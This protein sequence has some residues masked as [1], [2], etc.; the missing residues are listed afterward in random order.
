LRL[1]IGISSNIGIGSDIGIDI[2]IGIGIGIDDLHL[3]VLA[4]VF[5]REFPP[6]QPL[7][8]LRALG[9]GGSYY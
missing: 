3:A 5:L 8:L 1:D 7:Q 9:S 4:L 2:D 6:A